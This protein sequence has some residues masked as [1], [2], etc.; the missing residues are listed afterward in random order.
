MIKVLHRGKT[1][2][3]G[4]AMR[5]IQRQ[6]RD[7]L[8]KEMPVML[9]KIGQVCVFEIQANIM[10][11]KTPKGKPFTALQDSTMRI[12]AWKDKRHYRGITGRSQN[13]ADIL[14]ETKRRLWGTVK[15]EVKGKVVAIGSDYMT[16]S[17]HN[18]ATLHQRGVRSTGGMIP[19]KS[20]PKRP[21]LGF[22]NTMIR[23]ALN[24][25]INGIT[26]VFGRLK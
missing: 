19:G 26:K 8:A 15:H 2:T 13:P 20:I 12:R 17:G 16:P 24:I 14:K 25:T 9:D 6:L 23:W 22:S 3:F 11:N 18:L 21:T 5:S 4:Q 1:T 10:A 7:G